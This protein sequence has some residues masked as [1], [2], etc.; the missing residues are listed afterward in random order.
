MR[1]RH[2]EADN[3]SGPEEI[4]HSGKQVFLCGGRRERSTGVR[5]W[6]ELSKII[7]F[8]EGGYGLSS[9]EFQRV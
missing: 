2:L 8:S 1:E 9:L 6:E 5:E 7:F 4:P 3:V